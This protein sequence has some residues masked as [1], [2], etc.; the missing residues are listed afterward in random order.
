MDRYKKTASGHI[1]NRRIEVPATTKSGQTIFVELAVFPI[2]PGT[3]YA[4]GAFLHDI[5]ARQQRQAL[6]SAAS[7]V[8]RALLLAPNNTEALN[9]ICEV[10]GKT[11]EFDFAALW[12]ENADRRILECHHVWQRSEKQKPIADDSI[13]RTFASGEGLPGKVWASGSPVVSTDIGNEP[14]YLRAK[15]AQSCG[16][17]LAIII[18]LMA[19]EKPLGALELLSEKPVNTD[20]SLIGLLLSSGNQIAQ[21]IKRI[22]SE[23]A[24]VVA[25]E[26][27]NTARVLAE[28]VLKMKSQLLATVSHEV[29]TPMAGVIGLTELLSLSD[30]GEEDNH[31]V[32]A[33]FDSSKRLLHILNDVLDTSKLNEGKLTLENRMFSFRVVLDEVSQLIAPD[34]LNK[35]LRLDV[36]C[37]ASL[38]ELVCGD[39]LRLR[40]VLL[41][42]ATNA[43]KFCPQGEIRIRATVL[44]QNSDAVV[45][46][47]EVSDT[48]LGIPDDKLDKIFEPFE[49]AHDFT[50]RMYG[51]TGLG[52]SISKNLV[53]LMNGQIGVRSQPDSGSTFWFN[54]PFRLS[55]RQQADKVD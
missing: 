34:V 48:G 43:V 32:R 9:S 23:H 41:N 36:Q 25:K 45:I 44:E 37:H 8:T 27:A 22:Q 49:Q 17:K 26:E 52:L 14:A 21:F 10:A 28:E 29:R 2:A 15:V 38:P 18:P 35:G 19:E 55:E 12:L 46:H 4:F 51:G 6:E 39:E 1:L 31:T 50:A 11:A 24:L 3:P 16:L 20:E 30:L 13:R 40:Q 54:L 7:K 42:L 5:T 53:E 47:V 33:I